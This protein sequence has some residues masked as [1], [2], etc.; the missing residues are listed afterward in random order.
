M[1]FLSFRASAFSFGLY[2]I[3]LGILLIALETPPYPPGG[4]NR[5]GAGAHGYIINPVIEIPNPTSYN[6]IFPCF[7]LGLFTTLFSSILKA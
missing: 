5:T 1:S 6:G 2:G 4:G 7:F 3:I